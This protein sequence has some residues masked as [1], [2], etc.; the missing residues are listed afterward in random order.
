ME[1]IKLLLH[2]LVSSLREHS[3]RAR[4]SAGAG[5]VVEYI[6][7]VLL[8]IAIAGAVAIGIKA[9]VDGKIGELG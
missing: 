5:E 9:W 3:R 7:M 8:G 4:E 2:L 1:A 6:L